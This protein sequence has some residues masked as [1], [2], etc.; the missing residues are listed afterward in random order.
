MK[1]SSFKVNFYL[2]N[3]ACSSGLLLLSVVLKGET[4]ENAH[5]L[6]C[7]VWGKWC[8]WSSSRSRSYYVVQPNFIPGSKSLKI[9]SRTFCKNFRFFLGKHCVLALL[10]AQ[11]ATAVTATAGLPAVTTNACRGS[12]AVWFFQLEPLLLL[13]Q[14]VQYWAY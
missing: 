5:V 11:A 6:F 8:T 4:Q 14:R 7:V 12:A 2:Q 10:H 3:N 13:Q 9:L 1:T